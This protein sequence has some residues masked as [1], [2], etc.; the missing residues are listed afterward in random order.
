MSE[1]IS[2]MQARADVAII[3][4]NQKTLRGAAAELGDAVLS[5]QADVTD[6]VAIEPRYSMIIRLNFSG[7]SMNIKCWPPSASS[8]TSNCEPLI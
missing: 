1:H 3:G 8:N 6:I 5:I 4:R 2:E 7:F